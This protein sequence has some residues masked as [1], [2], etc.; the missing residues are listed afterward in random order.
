MPKSG[1]DHTQFRYTLMTGYHY[2]VIVSR[3]YSPWEMKCGWTVA[4]LHEAFNFNFHE[5]PKTLKLK[6]HN[7]QV[8]CTGMN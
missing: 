2:N 7:S 8:N 4:T 6:T 3:L 5:S 1:F